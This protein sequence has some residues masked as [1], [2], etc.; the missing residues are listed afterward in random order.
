MPENGWRIQAADLQQQIEGGDLEP[1]QRL[2]TCVH[3]L[4]WWVNSTGSE[5]EQIGYSLSG[6]SEILKRTFESLELSACVCFVFWW[7]V[8]GSNQWPLPCEGSALPLS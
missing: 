2:G 4:C 7:A 3:M 8:L 1:P 5:C 6:L